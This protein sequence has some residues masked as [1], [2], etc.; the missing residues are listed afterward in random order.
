MGSLM[1]ATT[2]S[3]SARISSRERPLKECKTMAMASLSSIRVGMSRN[4]RTLA[5][6]HPTRDNVMPI[7]PSRNIHCFSPSQGRTRRPRPPWPEETGPIPSLLH[8]S[9]T[10]ASSAATPA[11]PLLREVMITSCRPN[12]VRSPGARNLTTT[13]SH[14]RAQSHYLDATTFSFFTAA[15]AK[16]TNAL[17]GQDIPKRAC[18]ISAQQ[19]AIGG[20]FL[21]PLPPRPSRPPVSPPRARTLV[22]HVDSR[23][24]NSHQPIDSW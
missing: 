7:R 1:Q 10:A 2:F 22:L 16:R 20:C 18:P 13:A 23:K 15:C 8:G 24:R 21:C 11:S 12:L 5:V 9:L 17:S 14:A 3:S 4:C 6:V 19:T